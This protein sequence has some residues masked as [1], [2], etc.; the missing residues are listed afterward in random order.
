MRP[1]PKKLL[2]HNISLSLLSGSDGWNSTYGDPIAI[3]HV[4]IEPSSA[5]GRT[6]NSETKK[7]TAIL[8]MDRQYSKPYQEPTEG[9]RVTCNGKAYEVGKVNALYD[10]GKIPHHYEV[11]LR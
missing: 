11:E 7:S 5:L 8:F 4:R 10:T 3:E 1:I 2:I 9:S 6:D